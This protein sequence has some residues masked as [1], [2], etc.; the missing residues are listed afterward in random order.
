MSAYKTITLDETRALLENKSTVV[1][2]TLPP[3]HFA[4]RHIPGASNACVYEMV[5]LDGV[6]AL[7]PDKDALVVLYGAGP[8]S[9]DAVE[10]A[11][12]LGR[13]GYTNLRVFPGG[14]KE[15]RDAGYDL[16]GDAVD[17]VEPPHP[18]IT[19]ENRPYT[20]IPEESAL[21]WTGRN[22]NGAHFGVLSLKSGEIHGET[23]TGD[24]ALD[25]TSI[26]NVD[27]E[28]D[29]LQ[30]VLEAHLK[31][32]DFFFTTLFPEAVFTIESAKPIDGAAPTQQN[33]RISG[34]LSLRGVKKPV[35]FNAS[36]KNT[37]ETGEK[38]AIAANLDIDRTQ[39]GVLY[40]SARFFHHLSYHVVYDLISIDFRIV[41]G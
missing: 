40:G 27:L 38:L 19:I 10:A 16:A 24:V 37:G 7:V 25:M 34:A 29:E 22:D 33:Y 32:D 4:A 21:R 12:K 17:V 18:P 35:T 3:E 36:V 5:F 20:L 28:G 13:A 41:L 11:D 30:P 6:S 1:V 8:G 14:L 26:K 39:W 2:D 31:S 15:W 9:R 23:L